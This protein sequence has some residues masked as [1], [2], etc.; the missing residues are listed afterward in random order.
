MSLLPK[1]NSQVR[2]I[3]VWLVKR[4]PQDLDQEAHADP[5]KNVILALT[6]EEVTLLQQVLE[7]RQ[8]V[9]VTDHALDLAAVQENQE[10]EDKR[11]TIVF[12]F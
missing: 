4:L 1:V 6:Q 12:P 10:A 3:V 2:V 9:Y 7:S 8:L 5:P 11:Q